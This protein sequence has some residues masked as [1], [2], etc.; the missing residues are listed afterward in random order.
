MKHLFQLT[1]VAIAISAITGSAFADGIT[2]P[3]IVNESGYDFTNESSAIAYGTDGKPK[4]INGVTQYIVIG[5]HKNSFNI[6]TENS[7][8]TEKDLSQKYEQKEERNTTDANYYY[9]N[10][11][12]FAFTNANGQNAYFVSSVVNNEYKSNILDKTYR[13][14]QS[15][16]SESLNNSARKS[17]TTDVFD[18]FIGTIESENESSRIQ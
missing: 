10:N 6:R 17:T 15:K 9:D 7:P 18:G 3:P 2:L 8:A 14:N 5:T 4:Q 16:V 11:G 13:P 1:A 12:E